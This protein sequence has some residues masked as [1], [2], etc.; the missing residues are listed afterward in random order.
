MK[1]FHL[2]D[3]HIGKRLFEFSLI[4]DQRFI[5]NQIL[6][7]V[8]IEKPDALMIAGDIY[9]KSAPSAE[10]VLLFDDFLSELCL[11]SIQVFVISGN[12]DSP[13][14]IAFGSRIVSRSGVFLSP[15]YNGEVRPITM[16]DEHGDVDFYLLPFIKPSH[17]RRFFPENNINTYT[18]A[19]STA[20]DH[21]PLHKG[22]RNVLITHQFVT[23]ASKSDSEDVAVGGSDNV[24]AE[25]FD[26]FDYVALGHLHSPQNIGGEAIRYCG[27]PLKYSVSES[28]QQKSVTVVELGPKGHLETRTLPLTPIRDLRKIKGTYMFVTD[29]CNYEHSNT[30]DYLQITLTDENDIPD[31]MAKLRVIYPNALHLDYDNSRTREDREILVDSDFAM[32]SPLEL[33][34][35]FYELQNNQPMD[36]HQKSLLETLVEC[37][38]EDNK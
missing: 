8:R 26:G 5:L 27:T 36:A 25:V 21:L 29:R 11:L 15:V 2:S 35:H 17:V 24:D 23:G 6:N 28:S 33:F 10:A 32:R 3:L 37:I 22:R 18:D 13:E 14:R 34:S 12:H 1:I 19:M 16:S 9:D 20:L 31:A 7:F 38:W 4:E 30:L